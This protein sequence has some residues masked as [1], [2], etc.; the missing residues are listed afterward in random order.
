M[1]SVTTPVNDLKK[2][3]KNSKATTMRRLDTSVIYK[4]TSHQEINL[5]EIGNFIFITFLYFYFLALSTT[6]KSQTLQYASRFLTLAAAKKP[7]SA[8]ARAFGMPVYQKIIPNFND[9]KNKMEVEQE[10]TP[11]TLIQSK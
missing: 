11:M 10:T 1:S 3:N 7:N 6:T 9:I 2:T 4:A 8:E 5:G